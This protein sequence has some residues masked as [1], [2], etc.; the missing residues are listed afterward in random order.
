[1]YFDGGKYL[2][3]EAEL[4]IKA[5]DLEKKQGGHTLA[6][7]K[8]E[9]ENYTEEDRPYEEQFLLDQ[10]KLSCSIHMKML[11]EETKTSE[12]RTELTHK[13]KLTVRTEK[14]D[15]RKERSASKE[16]RNTLQF[17]K[18]RERE[19]EREGEVKE[20]DDTTLQI[21]R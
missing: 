21:L 13:S 6:K 16:R 4:K 7:I 5:Y 15:K 8:L 17:G 11:D 12:N 20:K 9:L 3:K 10:A 14:L 18:E 1:M 19:R 2:P